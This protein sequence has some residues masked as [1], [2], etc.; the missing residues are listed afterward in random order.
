[1]YV[2]EYIIES[3][4]PLSE[5]E[6]FPN[7]KET[8]AFS[9]A[10][11]RFTLSLCFPNKMTANASSFSVLTAEANPVC[12]LYGF[13]CRSQFLYLCFDLRRQS[14]SSLYVIDCW[15]E[16]CYIL[17]RLIPILLTAEAS[18]IAPSMNWTAEANIHDLS[19]LTA[20]INLSFLFVFS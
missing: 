4:T 5:L 17:Q 9:K 13:D 8:W 2:Y 11:L 12:S 1:M 20:E 6:T 10:S 16:S 7:C 15:S 3:E 14:Q 19:I 18:H